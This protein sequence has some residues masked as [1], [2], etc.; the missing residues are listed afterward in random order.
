MFA[1][2]MYTPPPPPPQKKQ[3]VHKTQLVV[4][5]SLLVEDCNSC[6]H[7]LYSRQHVLSLS[8]NG[9]LVE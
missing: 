3:P 8:Q 6:L 5:N 7:I 1:F 4:S 2:L 9:H